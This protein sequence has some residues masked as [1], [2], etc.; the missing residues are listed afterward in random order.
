[1]TRDAPIAIPEEATVYTNI[2]PATPQ[3]LKYGGTETG[4]V[5]VPTPGNLNVFVLALGQGSD[6]ALSRETETENVAR[7]FRG[8]Y[9]DAS[10]TFTCAA[11]ATTCTDVET[12]TN[13]GGQR[14]L[15]VQLAAG[16]TFESDGYVESV[17]TPDESYLYFGYWLQS[18]VNPA[19]S[20]TY[21]F[22]TFFGGGTAA[23]FTVLGDLTDPADALTATYK[24]GAAGRY[25]TRKLSFTNQGV[26]PK[27]PAYHGRFTANAE[28]K[29]YFGA[30]P[31]F[32]VVTDPLVTDPD[33]NAP[34]I[35]S[36]E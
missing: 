11:A 32:A 20:A 29:A 17:A 8:A 27:S 22:S 33:T 10:G 15:T 23:A 6:G 16:W 28:L 26:D 24:G 34:I 1:M 35:L 30:H 9:G 4:D 14:V 19:V 13:D 5:A 21:S 12:G 3:K 7:T 2:K 18:P 36:P 25:V 31:S